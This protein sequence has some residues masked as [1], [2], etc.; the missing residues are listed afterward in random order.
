MSQLENVFGT[1]T[2]DERKVNPGVD[3]KIQPDRF[4]KALIK[5]AQEL[6]KALFDGYVKPKSAAVTSILQEGILDPEMDWYE[7]P[8]PTGVSYC[9]TVACG[10]LM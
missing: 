10:E 4:S 5:V 3:E 9:H 6:D 2:E 1:S 8:Q 7:T